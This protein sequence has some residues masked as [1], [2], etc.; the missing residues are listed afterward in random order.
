MERMEGSCGHLVVDFAEGTVEAADFIEDH[1]TFEEEPSPLFVEPVWIADT[2]MKGAHVGFEIEAQE[3]AGIDEDPGE[4]GGIVATDAE[5]FGPVFEFGADLLLAAGGDDAPPI[6]HEDAFAERFEFGEDMTGDE[7]VNPKRVE[8]FEE[9]SHL[10]A[11]ER[12]ESVHGFIEHEEFG[13]VQ[14]GLGEFDALAHPLGIAAHGAVPMGAIE[15]DAV[16]SRLGALRKG[17]VG[18]A[19][20]QPE[21]VE[22]VAGFQFGGDGFVFGAEAESAKEWG[23]VPG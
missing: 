20:E 19:G 3:E 4:A 21:G 5:G 12:V 13:I 10:L 1:A 14:E 2:E 18:K 11:A 7:D 6:Q 22:P 16:E 9:L 17:G 8:L 23:V 15:F